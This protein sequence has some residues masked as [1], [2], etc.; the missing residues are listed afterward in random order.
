MQYRLSQNKD[1]SYDVIVDISDNLEEFGVDFIGDVVKK[2][3]QDISQFIKTKGKDIS[4]KAVKVVS[5][6]VIISTIAYSSFLSAMAAS[7]TFSMSY[8]YGGTVSQQIS[9]VDRTNNALDVVSPSYFDIIAG[10]SLKINTISKSF[11]DTMHGKGIRVVPFLSNHWDRTAGIEALKNVDSMAT[12]LASLI[13]QNNL[14]GINV[15]IENVTHNEKTAYT[16]LVAALRKKIPSNK[17]V[18]VAVAANPKGW[19]TGWHGSYD[20]AGLAAHADYLM[21]MTYDESYQGG[22]PG[23]VASIGFVEQSVTYALKYAPASKICIGLPFYGRVWS[24]DNNF[25][26]LGAN[27]NTINA[28]NSTY[29][30]SISYNSTYKSPKSEFT[31]KAGDTAMSINGKTLAPGKYTVWFENDS[32]IAAKLG[33]V[34]KYNLKGAGSWSLGQEPESIWKGYKDWIGDIEPSSGSNV[35]SS[36]TVSSGTSSSKAS[37][38]TSSPQAGTSQTTKAAQSKSSVAAV[39]A[40][41]PKTSTAQ[42]TKVNSSAQT[43]KN[44]VS[45]N[46]AQTPAAETQEIAELLENSENDVPD[47]ILD[48]EVESVELSE[49]FEPLTTF[50]AIDSNETIDVYS[51]PENG[52]KTGILIGSSV[53]M[54]LGITLR[55]WYKIKS[56][57]GHTGFIPSAHISKVLKDV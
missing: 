17:E 40:T 12:Q 11:V 16:A 25:N 47:V 30:A 10:G 14:D 31:V 3:G 15:D 18:S 45:E 32:S 22:D 41:V 57:N 9:Y 33:L 28:I 29:K 20:Y 52:K 24:E 23:P 54:L 43:N 44:A 56:K 19:T 49:S 1:G 26:G 8:L 5:A 2:T 48:A 42:S 46:S 53:V 51:N 36:G 55:G 7:N 27:L 37:S 35:T 6:G 13:E 21:I 39:Q 38:V 50:G 34:Q 4:I